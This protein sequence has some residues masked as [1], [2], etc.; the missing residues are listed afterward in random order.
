MANLLS[1]E[2]VEQVR[3]VVLKVLAD[4]GAL[5]QRSRG[6]GF[7]ASWAEGYLAANLGAS[8]GT[9]VTEATALM[10]VHKVLNRGGWAA[11]DPQ[12]QIL[13]TNRDD[14]LTGSTGDY[15]IAVKFSSEWRPI[16]VSC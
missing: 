9:G 3:R 12:L 5:N 2:A 11:V 10:T 7:A 1:D 16:W 4:S 15:V 14:S 8:S 6:A 13:L